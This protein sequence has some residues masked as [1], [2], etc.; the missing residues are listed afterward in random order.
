MFTEK[1]DRLHRS[2]YQF[3]VSEDGTMLKI[4]GEITF[5]FSN[6][7]PQ[8]LKDHPGLKTIVLNSQGCLLYTSPSPR[9]AT[10]SRMPSSA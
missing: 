5:G 1:K 8:A 10:L 3:K 4:Q 6:N 2:A 7:F 9:D